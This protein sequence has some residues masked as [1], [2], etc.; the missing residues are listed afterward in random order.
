MRPVGSNHL[1]GLSF[2]SASIHR[3]LPP[4]DRPSPA[5]LLSAPVDCPSVEGRLAAVKANVAAVQ[6]RSMMREGT[7]FYFSA[8]F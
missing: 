8:C 4:S 5:D 3:R 2:R 7:W 6:V 1:T